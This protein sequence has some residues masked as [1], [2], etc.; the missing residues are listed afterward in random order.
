MQT[1]TGVFSDRT[2][3]VLA[4]EKVRE[5]AG[6]R[7]SV[8]ALL[9][10][11]GNRVIET[12]VLTDNSALLRMTMLGAGLG[13]VAFAVFLAAGT[14][15]AMSLV[16]LLWGIAT[17]YMLGLWLSG[18]AYRSRL[19]GGAEHTRHLELA[20]Q[21]KA[22]IVAVVLDREHAEQ[23][24]DTLAAAG[25]AVLASDAPSRPSRPAPSAPHPV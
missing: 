22:V 11:D 20:R 9:P 19:L 17:G 2:S 18:E 14:S 4:A 23:V 21:G 8:R 25:G 5:V 7:A 12:T 10:G 15:L 1:V 16:G 24:S 13:A 3:A 6:R